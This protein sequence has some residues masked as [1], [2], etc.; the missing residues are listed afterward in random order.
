MSDEPKNP[1]KEGKKRKGLCIF[2]P[3]TKNHS[4]QK[5][6][7]NIQQ[8]IRRGVI[9]QPQTPCQGRQVCSNCG[10][11]FEGVYCPQ[12]G[13]S[14]AVKRITLGRALHNFLTQV[15]GLQANLPRTLI[16]LLYRPGY[17]VADYLAGKRRHYANPFSTILLLA[18]LFILANQYMMRTDIVEATSHVSSQLSSE[19]SQSMGVSTVESDLSQQMALNTLTNIYNHFGLFNLLLV[20]ILTLPFWLVFRKEGSYRQ[21]PMNVAEAT[22]TMAFV[23]CQNLIVSILG[24]PFVTATNMGAVSLAEY[25]VVIPLFLL[26]LWQMFELRV[27]RYLGRLVLFGLV[28]L[29][30]LLLTIV[31]TSIACPTGW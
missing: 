11:E 19:L 1:S 15:M 16:D 23:G 2:V 9:P 21:S 25:L 31:V 17:L 13:Q 26:T 10:T 6:S 18:T 3:R 24:L 20:P 29:V 4:K 22:T 28:C 7:M 5:Q 14:A 12:C 30:L 8:M 27:G